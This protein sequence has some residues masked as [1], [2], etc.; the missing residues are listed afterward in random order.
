MKSETAISHSGP[1]VCSDVSAS[2]PSMRTQSTFGVSFTWG[3]VGDQ[4]LDLARQLEGSELARLGRGPAGHLD[5][6]VEVVLLVPAA[7]ALAERSW[8]GVGDRRLADPD[9]F[10]LRRVASVAVGDLDRR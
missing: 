10:L 1:S 2:R 8:L 5:V 6:D 4:V 9:P 7:L 3:S